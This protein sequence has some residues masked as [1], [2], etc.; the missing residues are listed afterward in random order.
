MDNYKL[1]EEFIVPA[2]HLQYYVVLVDKR[3]KITNI[4]HNTV[5]IVWS[6]SRFIGILNHI[7]LTVSWKKAMQVLDDRMEKMKDHIKQLTPTDIA[8]ILLRG[9]FLRSRVFFGVNDQNLATRP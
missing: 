7:G 9:D 4:I 1:E 5:Y 2:M 3:Q 6:R 8:I